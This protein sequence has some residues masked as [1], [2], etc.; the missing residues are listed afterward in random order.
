MNTYKIKCADC[1]VIYEQ[2]SEKKPC[3]C[4]NCGSFW[5]AVK[6]IDPSEVCVRCGSPLISG[7]IQNEQ[8]CSDITCP[9]SDYPQDDFHGWIGH[10]DHPEE[11]CDYLERMEQMENLR[12]LR[13]LRDLNREPEEINEL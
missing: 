7:P 1:D 3:C 11:L 5:I 9:F 10:P 12:D 6:E 2:T 8:Y 13:D 4:G